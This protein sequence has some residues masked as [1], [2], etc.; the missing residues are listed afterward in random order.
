MRAEAIRPGFRQRGRI[1]DPASPSQ[2]VTLTFAA[3]AP[4]LFTAN[5]S[6]TGQAAVVN[7]DG[8]IN[9]PSPAGKIVSVYG[10]GFG[11]LGATGPDGLRRLVLPVTAT[12]GGVPVTVTYAGEAP[13]YTTG[14]Q[15]INLLIGPDVPKGGSAGGGDGR[16]GGDTGA[17]DD[18]CHLGGRTV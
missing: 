13:G 14:L 1:A 15:Q 7:Q 6:G 10:T 17:G 3:A 11:L 12:V 9:T 2:P 5:S 18:H 16:R 4:G 8:T